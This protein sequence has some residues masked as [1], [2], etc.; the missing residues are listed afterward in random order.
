[1][2]KQIVFFLFLAVVVA[3]VLGVIG[4][5]LTAE[6]GPIFGVLFLFCLIWAW[7]VMRSSK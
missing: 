1:M 2:L 4:L 6:L 7:F 5:M 3:T